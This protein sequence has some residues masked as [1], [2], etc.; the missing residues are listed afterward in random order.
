MVCGKVSQGKSL[1]KSAKLKPLFLL[2]SQNYLVHKK[3]SV[4]N[5]EDREMRRKLREGLFKREKERKRGL[6]H[7]RERTNL[8]FTL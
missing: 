8:T 2:D 3:I 5:Y 1:S 4:I 7:S 6:S